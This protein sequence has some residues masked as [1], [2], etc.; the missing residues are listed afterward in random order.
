MATPVFRVQGPCIV[1]FGPVTP[2]TI[3]ETKDGVRIS[4]AEELVPIICDEFGDAPIDYILAGKTAIV[5]C[6]GMELSAIKTS[7]FF[8]DLIGKSED[9]GT[10]YNA[11]AA[12]VYE[13][14][15]EEREG[16]AV[17]WEADCVWPI[18][19][20]FAMRTSLELNIPLQFRILPDTDGKLFKTIPSYL[21]S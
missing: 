11:N 17:K 18:Y 3:G 12:T 14:I 19:N 9:V 7:D 5:E 20:E 1:K 8:R 13:L 15:I 21:T 4:F 2:V 6:I 10:L 16:T